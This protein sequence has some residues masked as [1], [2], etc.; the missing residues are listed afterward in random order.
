MKITKLLFLG[1]AVVFLSCGED[2]PKP[3]SQGIL[4]TWALTAVEYTGTSTTTA[5][6]TSIKADYT[7]TGKDIQVTTTFNGNPN[8]V[9]TE[10][11][12]IIVLETTMMGQTS[13]DEFPFDDV[14]TDGTWTLDG[15]TLT[16][17]GA[18]GPQ[19]ATIL[20]Q[21]S[22]ALKMR[23]DFKESVSNMDVTVSTDIQITYS[24]KKN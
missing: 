7:G 3:T 11:S 16:I 10:G 4:G 5:Q 1:L 9:T 15:S 23:F 22:T 8:T 17:T 18:N 20:E 6:G 2:D 12:Y 13:T 19:K 24:F 14:V 21:T